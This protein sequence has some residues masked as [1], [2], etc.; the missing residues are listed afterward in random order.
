MGLAPKHPH[1]DH[2]DKR[3]CTVKKSR[4]LA[5]FEG[6]LRER[7]GARVQLS[8]VDQCE[9]VDLGREL[10]LQLGSLKVIPSTRQ[11][12]WAGHRRTIEPRTM[13][14]LVVLGRSAGTIVSRHVLFSRCWEGRIVGEGSLN[15]VMTAIRGLGV[16]SGAFEIETVIKVGYRLHPLTHEAA[17]EPLPILA[18]ARGLIGRRGVIGTAVLGA[19]LLAAARIYAPISR[20]AAPPPEAVRLVSHALSRL[21]DSREEPDAQMMADLQEAI[22]IAPEYATAWG[23]LALVHAGQSNAAVGAQREAQAMRT[24]E[25]AARAFALEPD[26][27]RASI[28]LLELMPTYGNWSVL[29][30]RCRDLLE[31][32]GRHPIVVGTLG[33]LLQEV[34]RWSESA[35]LFAEVNQRL[36]TNPIGHY[37]YI[38]ALWGAGRSGEARAAA[39]R[40]LRRFPRH[41]AIFQGWIKMLLYGARP[42][43][44]IAAI[45]DPSL[46]P[47]EMSV[48]MQTLLLTTARALDDGSQQ[49][50][51][52]ALTLNLN[53]LKVSGD[54][55][56]TAYRCAA[57]GSVDVSL[58]ILEGYFL[59]R[60][61]WSA[62]KPDPSR[63]EERWT[64]PLFQPPAAPLWEQPRFNRLLAATGLTAYWRE[65]RSV[66]DY[67]RRK[68]RPANA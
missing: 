44:A 31:P 65:T 66:P 28:A 21:R 58:T 29:E 7:E 60:G 46:R 54:A 10:P 15:R 32:T 6:L 25:L 34:G 8:P 40:A 43:E 45:Q 16:E 38:L 36:L 48:D 61:H 68:R 52:T 41:P 19:G 5:L 24:R 62:L 12:E 37:K 50:I 51:D 23:A 30:R 27:P 11:V 20:P 47:A 63:G 9:P 42:S 57:L 55:I 35:P 49:D 4:F 2:S 18:Q 22:R 33:A 17:A 26:E 14:V 67:I 59:G 3:E 39:Q 53:H 1:S 13:Q 64:G 56:G